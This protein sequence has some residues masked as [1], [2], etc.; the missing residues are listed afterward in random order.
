MIKNIVSV[1][2]VLKFIHLHSPSIINGSLNFYFAITQMYSWYRTVLFLV[3]QST[4]R[5]VDI[6][7]A[8]H[9]LCYNLGNTPQYPSKAYIG[10]WKYKSQQIWYSCYTDVIKTVQFDHFSRVRWNILAINKIYLNYTRHRGEIYQWGP[11]RYLIYST[12]ADVTNQLYQ[13]QASTSPQTES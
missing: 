13:V 2:L 4:G 8:S 5:V 3:F 10:S 1:C 9:I 7:V 12:S 11:G 6:S